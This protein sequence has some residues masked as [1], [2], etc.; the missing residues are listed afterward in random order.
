MTG[1][2][3]Q[4]KRRHDQHAEVN[5]GHGP[6][7]EDGFGNRADRR[8]RSKDDERPNPFIPRRAANGQGADGCGPG[9]FRLNQMNLNFSARAE[10]N[11]P[12]RRSRTIAATAEP[13]E[14]SRR[15]SG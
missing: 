7:S 15:R 5:E 11:D 14:A 9:I 2:P 12:Q 3:A 13:G 1:P 6:V 8:D 4:K 10:S